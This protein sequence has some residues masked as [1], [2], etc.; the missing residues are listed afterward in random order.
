MKRSGLGLS[1]TW[2]VICINVGSNLAGFFLVRL[3]Y[4]YAHPVPQWRE[5]ISALE[6]EVALA[7]LGFLVPIAV[8]ILHWLAAPVNVA[9]NTLEA[10]ADLQLEI[11]EQAKRRALNLPFLA[12]LMNL[13]A[14]I[15]PAVA[16]PVIFYV[17]GPVPIPEAIAGVAYNFTNAVMI[18]LLAFVLLEQ[19]CRRRIIPLLFPEGRLRDQKM[20]LGLTIRSRLMLLYAAI[21]FIPMF[22]TALITNVGTTHPST[23]ADLRAIVTNI[24]TFSTI[25]FVF[26]ATYGFWLVTLFA[27]N[28]SEPT[29]EIMD[30]TAK[31]RA[32]ENSV[33]VQVVSN[34]EI[35]YLGDRVNEMAKGLRERERIRK[36]L[37][38]FTS[39]EIGREILS[40]RTFEGAEIR[41]VTVLF[42]DLRG[43]ST[44]AE[45]LPPEL[46]LET[47]NSYF[48]EMSTAI[49]EQSGIIL[50]YV[51]DEIE[52]VFGAPLD[53]PRHA[54]KAVVAAL[55]MRERLAKLNEARVERGEEP[56]R[57]GIGI[58]TGTAL[59]GLVGSKYKLSYAMVGDTVNIASRI[60]DLTKELESEILI[61]GQTHDSLMVPRST[62]GPLT[63]SVK[64]KTQAVQVFRLNE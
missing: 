13:V 39:P 1:C 56:L 6:W 19:A 45:R 49:V 24:G 15:V 36:L 23:E 54:D 25:L 42:S 21:C 60:Q 16:F 26:I 30:A 4:Q 3:L 14:W 58:H 20:T 28:L 2:M 10:G 33:K 53:D 29:A 35:G 61:S 31:I 47:V 11:L 50:Q 38:L 64:G 22:Q 32:G 55:I 27:R 9:V 17:R 57:H 46:V 7:L 41:R 59:A 52:A 18:T 40:G 48:N 37:N 63:V 12:A 44:M 5:M 43:F 51:G 62:E 8:L 34:D